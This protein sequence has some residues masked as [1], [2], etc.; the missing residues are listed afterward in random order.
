MLKK[1]DGFHTIAVVLLAFAPKSKLLFS[2]GNDDKNSFAV[3]DWKAGTILF[4][5]PVSRG[6]VNAV[7][8]KSEN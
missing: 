5:G 7:C 6:K 4:S 1:L 2:V 3:Y 8:W